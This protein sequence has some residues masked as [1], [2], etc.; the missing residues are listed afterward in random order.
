MHEVIHS[1][2]IDIGTSTTQLIFS[3]LTIENEATSYVVPRINIV[4][5]K[6]TYR[7]QIYFTPLRSAT[8]I[9]GDKVRSIIEKEYR[10]AGMKPSDLQTGAVIITGET[11]RKQNANTVLDT[12]S[13]MAGDFVVATAGPDLESVL[14]ARGAGADVFSKENRNT[15]AN[16]D[17]GGGTSNIAVYQK[18][19][20]KG[21]SC[22]DVGGRLIKIDEAGRISYIFPGTKRL[23]EK[24]GISLN[25]GDRA[26]ERV[27]YR[28]C[29]L[30]AD[31]LAQAINL[32]A[33]DDIHAA[34]YTNDGKKLKEEPKID[35]VTYSGGVAS[36]YYDGEPNRV[37]AYGDIGVLLARAVRNNPLLQSVQTYRAVETI[38]AT[39]VGAGTHTT[40]VSGSTIQFSEGELPIKNIPVL[41]LSEMEEQDPALFRETLAR[42]LQIFK[43]EDQLEQVAIVL[44]GNYHS[45]FLQVQELAQMIIDGA[46]AVIAGPYPL[47]VVLEN[48]IAKALGN[49]INVFLERKKPFIC[50]DGI[51]ANDG[52]Y[53]DIGEPVA[54]GRVVPV[55]TKTLI[56]NS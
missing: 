21:T 26:D 47:I 55:V 32:K 24:H 16:L 28:V 5:K 1:V 10:D 35:A 12:L 48:D 20:L 25:V 19:V 38:R 43:T 8:E 36:V 50:V 30:M 6:V 18:G 53:L 52:D 15:V 17:I 39:V 37:F 44:S 4:D 34:M 46:A 54:L 45:S 13:N 41:K 23:A 31:Q 11:A 22:L 2:G 33:P 40:N 3:E 27:L 9:D 51:Y 56:F 7:S 14:S 29:E 42:K 49:A